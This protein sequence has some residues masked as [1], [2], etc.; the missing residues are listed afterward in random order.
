MQLWRDAS[1]LTGNIGWFSIRSQASSFTAVFLVVNDVAVWLLFYYRV[2]DQ[3][4]S[5]DHLSKPT[6]KKAKSHAKAKPKLLD[7]SDGTLTD[8]QFASIDLQQ[9]IASNTAAASA[10]VDLF[11]WRSRVTIFTHEIPLMFSIGLQC[12]P[13]HKFS[14]YFPFQ[15]HWS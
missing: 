7:E 6:K 9:Y 3:L 1:R 14:I 8:K 10:D 11:S 12:W 5:I 13:R 2:D 4:D 15:K